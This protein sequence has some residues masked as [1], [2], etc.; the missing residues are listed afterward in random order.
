MTFTLQTEG[1][2]EL[3]A[4]VAGVCDYI[5]AVADFDRKDRLFPADPT[6]F[7]TNPLSLA[8]GALGVAYALHRMTGEVAPGVKPWIL[9]QPLQSDR[10]PPGL[11]VGSSGIAWGLWEIGLPEVGLHLLKSTRKHPLLWETPDLYYGASG[12]GLTCLRFFG[13]T[14]DQIWL[15]EAMAVGEQLLHMRTEKE[16]GIC[17]PD[18]EGNVWTGYGRGAS[19]IALF[20]LYLGLA[21]GE[22][23]MLQAG[24]LALDFDL[25][26][27]RE[28]VNG[29]L[30]MRR[31]PITE[32][33]NV[34]SH[35]WSDGSAGLATA[36]VRYW[37]VTRDERYGA[38][39]ARLAEDACRKYTSFPGLF[40]GLAGL[41]NLLLDLFDLTGDE[42]YRHE[43]ER[44]AEGILL[45]RVH[46]PAGVAFP[47]EQLMRISTDFGTGSAGIGLFLHRLA[48]ADDRPG[49]FNFTLDQLLPG[50]G[51]GRTV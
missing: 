39:L 35:Y 30:S 24:R 19:G 36:L 43:A 6:L 47:G 45:F 38:L 10:Y 42:R 3:L 49:N 2:A 32:G 21:A 48:C 4:T 16:A 33:S 34:V 46:R 8:H 5:R 50:H 23:R 37:A 26:H 1:R 41:G 29:P 20:L 12:Y 22:D 18:A 7:V 44:V 9:S 11:Y 51:A 27:V 31:G 28:V 14:K 15:D 17:W 13:A 40:R 25:S